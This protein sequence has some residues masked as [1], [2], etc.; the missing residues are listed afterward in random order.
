MKRSAKRNFIVYC[1]TL[2][3]QLV[4]SGGSWGFSGRNRDV[5]RSGL[6]KP[7]SY[8]LCDRSEGVVPIHWK[9][10][11]HKSPIRFLRAVLLTRRIFRFCLTIGN[12]PRSIGH[13]HSW[14]SRNSLSN[15]PNNLLLFY[16]LRYPFP[17]ALY[18][19]AFGWFAIISGIGVAGRNKNTIYIY[20]YV[21]LDKKKLIDFYIKY[22]F[23][24]NDQTNIFT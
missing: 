17:L 22:K 15:A 4:F 5:E 18:A 6:V 20:R 11:W 2:R 7:W 23:K 13:L 1:T 14:C 16:F 19:S 9:I 10:V 12:Q 8:R 3:R 24:K 21:V